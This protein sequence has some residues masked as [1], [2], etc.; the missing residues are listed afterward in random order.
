MLLK[1]F[2]V[3]LKQGTKFQ[4]SLFTL[5]IAFNVAPQS[6]TLS[7]QGEGFKLRTT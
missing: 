7:Q 4:I 5:S 6:E 2:I 1:L 3:D